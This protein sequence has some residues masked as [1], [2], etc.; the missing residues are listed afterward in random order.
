MNNKSLIYKDNKIVEASYQLTLKEQRVVLM[1][2]SQIKSDEALKKNDECI[3]S[4]ASYA[5]TF[6]IAEK[7]ALKEIKEA[8]DEL[9]ERRINVVLDSGKKEK[10]R[11]VS[12]V[13]IDVKNNELGLRFSQDIIPFLTNLKGRFTKYQLSSVSDMKSV[14]SIRIYEMLMQWRTTKIVEVSI[15]KFKE[16]LELVDKY[17][18]IAN[19]RIKAIE[20]AIK[21]I[22]EY[23]DINVQ[24]ELI[25]TGKKFTG[26][27]FTF[28]YKNKST[29][30]DVNKITNTD[31][32]KSLKGALNNS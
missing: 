30:K 25:K 31:V 23:S 9:F 19:L 7:S 1:A 17:P 18:S 8:L 15:E 32:I 24:Y 6:G 16:R 20:P 21:E 3:L 28:S 13:T 2:I 5:A 11:W 10:F 29:E 14:F 26:I 4:V 12:K 27:K 22:N